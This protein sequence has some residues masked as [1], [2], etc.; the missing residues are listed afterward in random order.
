[1]SNE[2]GIT[3]CA[4][5]EYR[6][7]TRPHRIVDLQNFCDESGALSRHALAPTWPAYMLTQVTLTEEGPDRTRVTIEWEPY[8]EATP[9]EIETFVAGRAGM[10]AGWTG[11]FDKLEE[12]LAAD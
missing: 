3:M 2:Q 12:L 8:G 6:E 5:A 4:H 9:E 7:I 1:M 10:T 11:S